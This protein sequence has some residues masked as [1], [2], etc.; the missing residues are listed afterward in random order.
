MDN[1]AAI[2]FFRSLCYFLSG[3]MDFAS[4]LNYWFHVL[5]N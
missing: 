2:M 4:E 3:D 1:A 5:N